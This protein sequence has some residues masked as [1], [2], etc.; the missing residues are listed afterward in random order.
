MSGVSRVYLPAATEYNSEETVL[1]E[2][3]L[4]MALRGD[5]LN[6]DFIEGAN[7]NS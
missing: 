2:I 1:L 5:W 3:A 7:F 4:A 6:G